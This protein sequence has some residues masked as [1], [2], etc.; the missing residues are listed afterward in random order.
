MIDARLFRMLVPR[1][2]GGLEVAPLTYA[3]VVEAVS[4]YDST[5]GWALCNP[6]AFAFGC[7]R[8]PDQGVRR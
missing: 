8:L 3:R 2:L 4:R 1:S 6:G 7:F 5:A